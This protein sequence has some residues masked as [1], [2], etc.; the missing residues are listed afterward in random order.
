MKFC[1]EIQNLLFKVS[2]IVLFAWIAF[3]TLYYASVHQHVCVM[4]TM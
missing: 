2:N 4:K 3:I 1:I